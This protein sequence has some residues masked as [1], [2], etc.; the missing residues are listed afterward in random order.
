MRGYSVVFKVV[1]LAALF[2]L[3]GCDEIPSDPIEKDPDTGF[4]R[5][6]STPAGAAIILDGADAEA[7]TNALLT[8]VDR[9]ERVI[10]VVRNGYEAAPESVAVTVTKGDTTEAVFT[11]TEIETSGS[12]E[13]TSDP[14]GAAIRLDGVPTGTVTPETLEVLTGDHT[15]VVE[16]GGFTADPESIVVGVTEGILSIASFTFTQGRIVLVEHFTNTGCTGCPNAENALETI[17]DQY[18]YDNL[19]TFSCHMVWPDSQDPFY[20][21]N[22][23]Q[24]SERRGIFGVIVLPSVWVDGV[25]VDEPESYSAQLAAIQ[26]ALLVEPSYEI[27]VSGDAAGDSFVVNVDLKKLKSVPEGDE[28]LLVAVIETDVDFNAMNGMTHFDDA[29]RSFLP[30][31]GG[32]L[33]DLSVGESRAFRFAVYVPEVWTISNMEAIA[34]VESRSTRKVYQSNSTRQ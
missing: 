27:N 11:L 12:I 29:V 5:V 23:G 31:T 24:L 22:S 7:V 4:V 13:V 1:T 28:A 34:S 15:V 32:E 26:A 14:S 8:D 25:M 17:I 9:G 33:L 2:G 3:V 6:I 19:A 16:L 20:H 18:G 21:Q 10:R 30:D